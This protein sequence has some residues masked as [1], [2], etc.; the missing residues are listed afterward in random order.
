M[1]KSQTQEKSEVSGC[2]WHLPATLG[3]QQPCTRMVLM[4]EDNMACC[5]QDRTYMQGVAVQ[6]SM[7]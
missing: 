4:W 2:R 7:A 3:R 5:S 6:S 1:L